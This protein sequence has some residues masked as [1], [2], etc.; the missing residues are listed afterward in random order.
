MI[1]LLL[2][3]YISEMTWHESLKRRIR[4]G[5]ATFCKENRNSFSGLLP[6]IN[7]LWSYWVGVLYLQ[8][9]FKAEQDWNYSRFF[10]SQFRLDFGQLHFICYL[11]FFNT[12]LTLGFLHWLRLYCAILHYLRY[13]ALR[14]TKLLHCL[15]GM[16]YRALC[17]KFKKNSGQQLF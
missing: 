2:L 15:I 10:F 12:L 4:L 16:H 17:S 8:F 5:W 11:Q 7:S 14:T 1:I 9:H 3:S 6:N 13:P